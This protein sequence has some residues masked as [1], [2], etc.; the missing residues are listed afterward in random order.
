L[1]ILVIC[2]SAAA[3][4]QLSFFYA[5][6]LES[7]SRNSVI[8]IEISKAH[9]L[10]SWAYAPF[11]TI[12][13]NRQASVHFSPAPLNDEI[14][15][16]DYWLVPDDGGSDPEPDFWGCA[17]QLQAEETLFNRAGIVMQRRWR[18]NAFYSRRTS[19]EA[20]LLLIPPWVPAI[21]TVLGFA[22]AIALLVR[23]KRNLRGFP[24]GKG[25]SA[26]SSPKNG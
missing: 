19:V 12:S 9:I 4:A 3:I 7:P 14:K 11:R 5:V 17:N 6:F 10:V 26:H 22:T 23:R 2:L 21:P 1:V 8:G 25:K 16:P 18:L 24:M 20:S 15:L 13:I